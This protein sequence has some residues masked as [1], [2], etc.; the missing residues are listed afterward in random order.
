MKEPR[1]LNP[2]EPKS[3]TSIETVTRR[4]VALFFALTGF[5]I[6]VGVLACVPAAFLLNQQIQVIP[7]QGLITD[8]EFNGRAVS[9]KTVVRYS[10]IAAFSLWFVAILCVAMAVRNL[11][12]NQS[13]RVR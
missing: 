9:P 10:L 5:A 12:L 11:R 3:Q 13:V 6:L 1:G 7:T 4:P 2:Y 8:F